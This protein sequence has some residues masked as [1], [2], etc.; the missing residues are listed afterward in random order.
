[1]EK[2]LHQ[3]AVQ[4]FVVTA[5]VLTTI[6]VFLLNL[7]IKKK[8]SNEFL[9]SNNYSSKDPTS[10]EVIYPKIIFKSDRVILCDC[11]KKSFKEVLEDREKWEKFLNRKILDAR[12]ENRR[13]IIYVEKI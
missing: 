2:Y 9:H 10:G 1:M 3:Y 12:D 8:R 5:I 7:K 11:Y 6:A 13:T 4:L